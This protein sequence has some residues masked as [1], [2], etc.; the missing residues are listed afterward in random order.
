MSHRQVKKIKRTQKKF[1]YLIVPK[2]RG[3]I[4]DIV[5]CIVSAIKDEYLTSE[6]FKKISKLVEESIKNGK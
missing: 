2:E 5:D 3:K 1:K 6:D 4:K